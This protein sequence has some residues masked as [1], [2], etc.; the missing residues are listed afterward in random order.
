MA[1]VQVLLATAFRVGLATRIRQSCMYIRFLE[2]FT[3]S[4]RHLAVWEVVELCSA[5]RTFTS[6]FTLSLDVKLSG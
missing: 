4:I 1:L 3:P 6:L 5:Q 2:R